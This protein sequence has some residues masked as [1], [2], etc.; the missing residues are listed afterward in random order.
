MQT[1]QEEQR[2]VG[3]KAVLFCG[4]FF[5]F[6]RLIFPPNRLLSTKN[7]TNQ[8]NPPIPKASRKEVET[9]TSG[10]RRRA[11][12]YTKGMPLKPARRGTERNWE[13][14]GRGGKKGKER[15]G[16]R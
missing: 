13:R 8:D 5:F 2:R 14:R 1:I 16:G 11:H 15:G 6:A 3:S 9:A 10:R 7:K 12:S 4:G